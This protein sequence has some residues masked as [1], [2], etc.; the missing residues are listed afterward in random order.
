MK[1]ERSRER[2]RKKSREKEGT[3]KEKEQDRAEKMARKC[4]RKERKE[5]KREKGRGE[6][7]QDR[8]TYFEGVSDQPP[9]ASRPARRFI[10]APHRR[11]DWRGFGAR[12]GAGQRRT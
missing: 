8:I 9:D 4:K 6:A 11:E 1:E 3:C 12:R 5:R 7:T 2:G 10:D